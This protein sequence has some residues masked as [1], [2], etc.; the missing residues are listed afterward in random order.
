MN[1][2]VSPQGEAGGDEAEGE[3]AALDNARP[4]PVRVPD[5]EPVVLVRMADR[6]DRA[7]SQ[8]GPVCL[9]RLSLNRLAGR[10]RGRSPRPVVARSDPE[11][12][13]G[14]D[15][16]VVAALRDKN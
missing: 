5:V 10:P 12:A 9:P 1:P 7:P 6:H 4:R 2:S 8:G 13:G 16:V 11:I 3:S 15:K 14:E